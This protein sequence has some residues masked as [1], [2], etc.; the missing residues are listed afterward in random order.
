M[1]YTPPPPFFSG[2]PRYAIFPPWSTGRAY[3]IYN[4]RTNIYAY[5]IIIIYNMFYCIPRLV[6][7]HTR[8]R[9]HYIYFIIHNIL[10][11][12]VCVYYLVQCVCTERVYIIQFNY[13]K[14]NI[15]HAYPYYSPYDVLVL[16]CIT[17]Y[18]RRWSDRECVVLGCL[19]ATYSQCLAWHPTQYI[20]FRS[21]RTPFILKSKIFTTLMCTHIIRKCL[22]AL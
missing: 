1:V 22:Q 19:V 6:H 12:C 18:A 21:S 3:I 4:V 15:S 7:T 17:A 14:I 2:L 8:V 16:T 11:Y 10:L 13:K 20:T 9:A 5:D